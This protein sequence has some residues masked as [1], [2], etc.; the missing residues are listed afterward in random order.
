MDAG[1]RVGAG[2]LVR[3]LRIAES[4]RRA[5]IESCFT[6]V[7]DELAAENARV[8]GFPV[9][10]CDAIPIYAQIFA[11]PTIASRDDVVVLDFIHSGVLAEPEATAALIG[12]WR[13][14][15]RRVIL[16]DGGASQ[17]MRQQNIALDLD[18]LIAPYAGECSNGHALYRELLGPTYVPLS[19]S[20]SG[21]PRRESAPD[22]H[23]ILVTCGGSDPKS[24]TMLILGALEGVDRPLQVRVILGP[25]F[26]SPLGT[27]IMDHVLRSRHDIIVVDAPQD[28]AVP[29][30]CSDLAIATSGL[31]KYELAATG[32]PALLIANDAAHN[33]ADQP[34]I[35]EGSAKSL[36]VLGSI[37]QGA[38]ATAAEELL[39]DQS[40]RQNMADCG[41]RLV[42]GLGVERITR[43][44]MRYAAA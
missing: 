6:V 44:L 13:R 3:C 22:A 7:G 17:S 16:I 36:G 35:R 42:D 43:E 10:R 9:Q 39:S 32:T 29:M 33:S 28:L 19:R 24:V 21:L 2:H 12:A 18:L 27:R 31:T 25:M 30:T 41:Q 4:A 40:A 11:V 23:R 15:C 26:G 37:S 38:V 20:F 34:F 1:S 8:A 14:N 5:G